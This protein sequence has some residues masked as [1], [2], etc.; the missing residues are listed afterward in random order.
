MPRPSESTPLIGVIPP[1]VLD[2]LAQHSDARVSMP[3]V[4]TLII[5]QQQRGLR[6]MSA[7]PSRATPSPSASRSPPGVPERAVHDA[8][9]TTT[10]PGT[11]VRAEGSWRFPCATRAWSR[12]GC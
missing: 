11:L 8:Q 4:K 12:P 5:D 7:Q 9:N 3:A 6:E 2:R 10:L 1:Y